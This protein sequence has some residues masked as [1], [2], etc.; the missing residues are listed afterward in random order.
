MYS[1]RNGLGAFNPPAR[2]LWIDPGYPPDPG[3]VARNTAN[4]DAYQRALDMAQAQNNYDGC[5]QNAQ[6]AN[7]PQQYAE[8]VA[9]CNG[10][11]QIQA[12]PDVPTL[13]QYLQAPAPGY[14]A[15]VYTPL[16]YAPSPGVY[17]TLYGNAPVYNPPSPAQNPTGAG[18]PTGGQ[19]SVP[20]GSQ[21]QP[22]ADNADQGD[23]EGTLF[24]LKFFG[25]PAWAL[26]AGAA[27][28]MFGGGRGR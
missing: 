21:P 13:P 9:R 19:A 17:G 8:V 27:L 25:V 20:A 6:N 11:Y 3:I 24:D 26:A 16:P 1:L 5:M 15:P 28:F 23:S 18:A 22:T 10:Q 12:A 4:N 14:V 2:P 7:T